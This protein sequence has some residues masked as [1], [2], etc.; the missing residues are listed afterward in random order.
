M[1]PA[2]APGGT[3]TETTT[4]VMA[5]EARVTTGGVI[6]ADQPCVLLAMVTV[7]VS[8]WSPVLRRVWVKITVTP[9]SAFWVRRL[10]GVGPAMCLRSTP[11]TISCS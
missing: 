4:V 11:R 6:K 5:C 7:K 8:V 10:S 9:G 1:V 3:V 2:K